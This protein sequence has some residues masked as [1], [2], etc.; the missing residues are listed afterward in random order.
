MEQEL[1]HAR[2]F[3]GV[4]T[5]HGCKS[6]LIYTIRLSLLK[7]ETL[8]LLPWKWEGPRSRSLTMTRKMKTSYDIADPG[9][10]EG[11]WIPD[12]SEKKDMLMVRIHWTKSTAPCKG[13]DLSIWKVIKS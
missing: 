9:L 2:G 13:L 8:Q 5:P 11:T 7:P 3:I 6:E 10:T 12:I 4:K 1:T